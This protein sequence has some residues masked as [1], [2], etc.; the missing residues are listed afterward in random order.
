M[1]KQELRLSALET[2]VNQ[3][4]A[5]AITRTSMLD[6]LDQWEAAKEQRKLE[7]KEAA[8]EQAKLAQAQA[9]EAKEAKENE[10]AANK[11]SSPKKSN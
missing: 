11:K 2:T 10:A 8:K 7:A 5:T 4:Q 1:A 9:K 6:I 3:I